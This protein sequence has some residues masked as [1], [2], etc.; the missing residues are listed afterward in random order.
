MH[1][2]NKVNFPEDGGNIKGHVGPFSV[3]FPYVHVC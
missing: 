1:I 2:N 3:L